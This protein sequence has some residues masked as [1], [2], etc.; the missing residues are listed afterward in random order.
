MVGFEPAGLATTNK[1]KV[2]KFRTQIRL[3]AKSENTA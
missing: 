2:D 1:K 3:V